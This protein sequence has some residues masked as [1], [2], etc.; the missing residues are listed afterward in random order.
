MLMIGTNNAETELAVVNGVR[1]VVAA[2]RRKQ[3]KARILF[4]AI[5]PRQASPSHWQRQRNNRINRELKKLADG[6]RIVWLDF[7][8]RFLSDKGVLGKDLFPDLL[9]PN[10]TGYDIWWNEIKGFLE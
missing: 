2:M 8:A 9:H 7:N 1:C 3:P 10:A 4:S 5:F 6:E